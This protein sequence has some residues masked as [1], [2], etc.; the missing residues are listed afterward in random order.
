MRSQAMPH[1]TASIN[2]QLGKRSFASFLE[3]GLG[4]SFVDLADTEFWWRSGKIDR[5]LLL[6]PN[7]VH[8]S[9]ANQF[10][11]HWEGDDYRF[12]GWRGGLSRK[13]QEAFRKSIEDPRVLTVLSVNIEALSTSERA[14]RL[15]DWFC[16]SK[17]KVTV[18]ES[19]RIKHPS[20]A[21]TKFVLRIGKR[22]LLVYWGLGGVEPLHQCKIQSFG[23]TGISL[24]F[25]RA[26]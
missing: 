11:D 14:K 26:M 10:R 22:C 4:K 16:N 18:D 23:R 7:G 6:C 2:V 17:T 8:L 15:V 25:L 13:E 5:Y 12:F 21:R 20:S 1:Q 24:G 19:T 9:W 3:Q